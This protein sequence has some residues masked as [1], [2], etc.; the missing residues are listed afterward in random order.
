MEDYDDPEAEAQWLTERRKEV[1]G[2]LRDEDITHGDIGQNPAWYVSPYVSVWAVESLVKSGSI[3]WWAISGDCPN[4]YVSASDAKSPRE[5]V[6][7][8]AS[9][10]LEASHYMSRGERHP[11][12]VIG[13]GDNDA[14]LSP[15]LSSRAKLLLDWVADPEVWDDDC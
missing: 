7:A 15:M 10:W 5:A 4:D 12:F 8:I 9:L 3:G 1:L 13:S 6:R 14:E 2:Y 11:T